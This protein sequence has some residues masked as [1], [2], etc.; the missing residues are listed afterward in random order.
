MP[1]TCH[2]PPPLLSVHPMAP[3]KPK[4]SAKMERKREGNQKEK[5]RRKER[6]W[7]EKKN[8]VCR[9]SLL[10][11]VSRVKMKRL[12]YLKDYAVYMATC[13]HSRA[14]QLLRWNLLWRFSCASSEFECCGGSLFRTFKSHVLPGLRPPD[15]WGIFTSE[16]QDVSS[17]K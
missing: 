7:G 1:G 17:S 13:M 14:W 2:V 8:Q 6:G 15:I 9:G 5:K 16:K 3:D 11:M 4:R 12:F 10:C